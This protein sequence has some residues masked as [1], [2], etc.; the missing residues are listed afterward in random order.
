MAQW[1][2]IPRHDLLGD[3]ALTAG[4]VDRHRRSLDVDRVQKFRNCG[5]LVGLRI[6]GDLA[7]RDG[8]LGHIRTDHMQRTFAALARERSAH[9]LAIQAH[10]L[11]RHIASQLGH[12]AGK[13]SAKLLRVERAEDTPECVGARDAVRQLQEG[14]QPCFAHHGVVDDIVPAVCPAD[15]RKHRD[16][17]DVHQLMALGAID[18]RVLQTGELLL[19]P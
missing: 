12:E 8:V 17:D 1:L 2:R 10:L 9:R 18:S 14:P 15:H 6:D 4:G 16:D 11:A 13:A 7:Q 19:E 3:L 5:D